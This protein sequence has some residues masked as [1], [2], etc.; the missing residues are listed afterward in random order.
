LKKGSWNWNLLFII[1]WWDKGGCSNVKAIVR[2]GK[3]ALWLMLVKLWWL[4]V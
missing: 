3:L 4:I 1:Y 2:F